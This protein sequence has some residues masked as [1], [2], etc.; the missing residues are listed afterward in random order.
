MR[1]IARRLHVDGLPAGFVPPEPAGRQR[2]GPVLA[3]S[4]AGLLI[5]RRQPPQRNQENRRS[6]YFERVLSRGPPTG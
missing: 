3:A 2:S 6:K 4:S 5:K 1:H